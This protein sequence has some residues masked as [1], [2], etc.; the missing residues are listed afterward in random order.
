MAVCQQAVKVAHRRVA[1]ACR[2]LAMLAR[3]HLAE[4]H[5]EAERLTV[6]L[7]AQVGSPH[8][9][10]LIGCCIHRMHLYGPRH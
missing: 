9:W 5:L 6:E 4:R 1:A 2:L 10:L 8:E 3:P 7:T